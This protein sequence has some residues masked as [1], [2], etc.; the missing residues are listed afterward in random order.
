MFT[1]G[2]VSISFRGETPQTILRACCEAG[3]SRMEW[4]GD[5][6]VPVGDIARAKRV[7]EE[8]RAAGMDPFSYGSYFRVGVSPLDD[9]QRTMDTALA[10]GARQIRVWAGEKNSQDMDEAD[11]SA[12]IETA[13]WMAYMAREAGLVVATECHNNTATN[14]YHAAEKLLRAVNLPNFRTHWQPNQF[15][16]DAYNLE[17]ARA[18]L[19]WMENVH[20]FYWRGHEHF[21]LAEGE[22]I[23]LEYLSAVGERPLLLEFMHDGRLESLPETARTLNAWVRKLEDGAKLV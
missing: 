21:P 11:W 9:W 3:L 16:S 22:A 17:A 23:W 8:T 1:T 14:E 5:V 18:L 6:H 10:L 4:G 15:C 19:P 2:L 20:V 13:A 7:G 12:L